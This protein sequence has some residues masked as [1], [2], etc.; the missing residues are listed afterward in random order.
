M[1]PTPIWRRY[2]R[3]FGPDPAADVK[4]ELRFHLQAKID[5]LVTQGW[6]PESARQ[7]AARQFGDLRALQQIGVRIGE[8]MERG[9]RLKDH[10]NDSLQDVRYT[11]RTLSR[12]PGFAATSILILALAI[13][14]NIAVFSVV[15]ALLLRPLPFPDSRELVWI[16]PPPTGCGLSCATYSADAYE[17]F[18][19]QSRAYQDVT[20]YEAFTT[21]DNFRLTGRG[22]PE[23][24]TGIEVIGNFFQVLGVQP[25][26]GRLFTA[27]EAR[28]GPQPVTLLG[29]AYWRRQFNAD[30]A[31][32]GQAIELNG[33]PITVVGV[34]PE[35]FDFGAIFSPGAKVDLFTPLDL[36]LEHDW[37][38]IVTLLARLKPGVTVT[39]ALDDANRV[40]PNIYFNTKYPETLGRYK[41][42]LIPVPLKDYV[43][44]KL[45]RSLIALWCA[46]GAIL[47]IAGVNLS[48]LL[49]ARAVARAKEFAVRGAL[50]ASRSRIVRQLLMESLALSSAGAALGLGLALLL[51]AWLSH[52]G[53]V[54]LPLLG[55]LRIDGQAL[56]WT[57]LVAIST[58]MIFGL[59]P[60]LR[61][62]S[63]N[64]QEMLKDS[65][66]GAGLARKHEPLRAALV[67][68]E[69]A[70][71]CVL[72]VSAGLLLRSFVKVLDVDLGF[73]PGRAASI[74]VEYDDSAPTNDAR[75]GKRG[76]IFQQIITRV[77]AIPGVEAA[78][79]CD[80][81]PLGPN[82]SWDAP[83]PKGRTAVPGELPEPLVYVITPGFIHAMGIRLHGR[84]FTWT[85]GPH[86]DAVVLINASAARFYWP[87]EDA[88]GKILMRGKE[89]DRIV[90]V[91][92]DVHEENVEGA[93]GSQIYYPAT[94]QQ[95]DWAQL[96]VRTS[97]Q[98]ASLAASVLHALRALNPKQPAAEF[99]P[100][101]TIVDRAVSPRRFFMLLVAAFA[102]LGLLLAALGIYGVISYSVTQQS[103]AIG[104]RMALGASVGHVQRQVLV[105]TL[106]LAVAGMVLGTLVALAVARLISSLLFSTLS[107][108]LPTYFGMA[109][110]LLLVAA[111]SGYIPAR[112]ASAVNP[113]EVLRSY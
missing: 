62:A 81:L 110:A 94:Q 58:A 67:I 60:G 32:V 19:A 82:R 48:N 5:D 55:T 99:R 43:T 100:I 83:V 78:G 38:N 90:G 66:S 11:F 17:E 30:P 1:T 102:G 18:R 41:G 27:D 73:Q 74:Q 21:P 108:D 26:M 84:D 91:V 59:L 104:I 64:L 46:V 9:K 65:G 13:G 12:D 80:F 85:D 95:P 22:E 79:I 53:S 20:G 61:I 93:T 6:S 86:S 7:E 52:Q 34:L 31:I 35:S 45:R 68:F 76:E 75:R 47:L 105:R 54:A 40:A 37:G 2:A 29:N 77:S 4:D 49:L 33:T 14:A 44:G 89:E 87:G 109:L 70:L 24:A 92:D 10:W 101:Q 36:K 16:A 69:V 39:Q 50:G 15:N 112:R 51:I 96:V 111:I 72:L 107:W 98:P 97:M 56:G 88:V 103:Q 28:G 63:G 25:A 23:P 71:A 42:N 8:K 57:V 3:L 106:R 113:M